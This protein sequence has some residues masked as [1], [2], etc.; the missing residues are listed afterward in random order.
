V[1]W[2]TKI[3]ADEVVGCKTSDII[4]FNLEITLIYTDIAITSGLNIN[5][6]YEEK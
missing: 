2:N 3:V 6:K 5:N 4:F 1:Y